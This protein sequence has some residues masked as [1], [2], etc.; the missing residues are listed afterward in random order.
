MTMPPNKELKLTLP[1]A[2][3]TATELCSG[4]DIDEQ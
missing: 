4:R 2:T 3:T 1:S